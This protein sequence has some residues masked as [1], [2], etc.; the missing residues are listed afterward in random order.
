[1]LLQLRDTQDSRT[2]VS[3]AVI[4]DVMVVLT[5]IAS[6]ITTVRFVRY[7]WRRR[8]RSMTDPVTIDTLGAHV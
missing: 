5:I 6:L 4:M 8:R 1:M 7:F 3:G 2:R